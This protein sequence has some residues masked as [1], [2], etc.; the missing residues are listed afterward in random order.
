LSTRGNAAASGSLLKIS[1]VVVVSF[2]RSTVALDN[3]RLVLF[4]SG[5]ALFNLIYKQIWNS[6]PVRV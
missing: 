5:V 4:K 3:R 1:A 6:E 2:T